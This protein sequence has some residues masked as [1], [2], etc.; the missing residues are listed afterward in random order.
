MKAVVARSD[1]PVPTAAE[2]SPSAPPS[3]GRFATVAILFG[4]ASGAALHLLLTRDQGWSAL[5]LFC[6]AGLGLSSVAAMLVFRRVQLP[7]EAAH[8]LSTER[9]LQL[10]AYEAQPPAAMPDDAGI[11]GSADSES[12]G[13]LRNAVAEARAAH[14]A[15]RRHLQAVVA[16][17]DELLVLVGRDGGIEAAS[18][19]VAALI[20]K[21][22]PELLDRPLASVLPLFDDSRP[23]PLQHPLMPVFQ[24]L[25][26]EPAI[27]RQRFAA[28]LERRGRTSVQLQLEA[29]PLRDAGQPARTLL[30]RLIPRQAEL[31]LLRGDLPGAIADEVPDPLS[32]A[33]GIQHLQRRI[34]RLLVESRLDAARHGLLL[35]TFDAFDQLHA[36]CGI[37]AGEQRLWQLARR[38]GAA[39]AMAEDV[40]RISARHFVLL[41]PR[42]TDEATMAAAEALRASVAAERGSAGGSPLTLSIGLAMIDGNLGASAVLD[43][44]DTALQQ[45]LQA[46]G[47]RVQVAGDAAAANGWLRDRLEARALRLA[48]Q[49]ILPAEPMPGAP[50]APWLELLPRLEDEDGVWL[51]FDPYWPEIERLGLDQ[52]V[53]DSLIDQALSHDLGSTRLSIRLGGTVLLRDDFIDGLRARLLRSRLPTPQLCIAVDEAFIVAHPQRAAALRELLLPFGCRL[54]IGRYRGLDGLRALRS[55][56]AHYIRLHESQVMRAAGDPLDRAHLEWLV[57]SARLMGVRSVACA[58]RDADSQERMRLARVD[59]VQGAAVAPPTPFSH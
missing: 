23:E 56:P 27:D 15:Q 4:L 35:I 21:A 24:R 3:R 53:H 17:S 49:P 31:P 14:E 44:A 54:A 42:Q 41:L 25:Q 38:I 11:V 59:Y 52:Q 50:E 39:A 30:L 58:V 18:A 29:R 22:L 37:A 19:G 33:F 10:Q 7:L 46:G 12:L 57:H 9:M 1:D 36:R 16:A 48:A 13:Q 5:L 45:A 40:H 32:G 47:D 55:F 34:E 43:A 28:L 8:N 6:S 20:D 26:N 2:T 51:P